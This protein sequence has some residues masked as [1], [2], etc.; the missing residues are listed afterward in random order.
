VAKVK[1]LGTADRVIIRK[2]EKFAGR[3]SEGT[4]QDLV[5][6]GSNNHLLDTDEAGLSEEA[7]A[8]L[9]EDDARFKD[10]TDMKR[11]PSSST[12]RSSRVTRPPSLPTASRSPSRMWTRLPTLSLLPRVAALVVQV[13]RQSRAQDHPRVARRQQSAAP[14]RHL[15]HGG[16]S[17]PLSASRQGLLTTPSR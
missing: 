4:T 6:D 11:I 10:V 2:G 7:L 13:V 12:S 5:W 8:L 1:Y 9:L 15:I 16:S 17:L 14:R 3:L